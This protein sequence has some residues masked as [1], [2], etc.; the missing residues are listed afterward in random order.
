MKLPV[1]EDMKLVEAQVE[2]TNAP[3]ATT[4]A[5]NAKYIKITGAGSVVSCTIN[6]T[7][8]LT[9]LVTNEPVIGGQCALESGGNNVQFKTIILKYTN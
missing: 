5:D 8:G 4:G 1:I 9:T 3:N 2:V 6:S 7:N